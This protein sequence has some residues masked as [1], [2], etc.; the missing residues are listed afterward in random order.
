M[1]T[2]QVERLADVRAEAEP[3]LRRHWE[4]IALNKDK[5]PLDPDWPLIEHMDATGITII[6]TARRD[7]KLVG[8]VCDLTHGAT[9]YRSLKVAENFVFWLD[10]AE[11]GRGVGLRLLRAAEAN[12]IERGCNKIVRH[13]KIKNP[14]AGRVLEAL[15]YVATDIIYSKVL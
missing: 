15:G 13:V 9:G 2:F 11:R 1:L 3:L 14:E 4:E 12:A 7:G 10:P 8:Y 5:V 6:T